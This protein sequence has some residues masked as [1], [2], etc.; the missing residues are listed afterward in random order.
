MAFYW[1][2]PHGNSGSFQSTRR[3]GDDEHERAASA[4]DRY[5]AIEHHYA[6]S[7]RHDCTRLDVFRFLFGPHQQRRARRIG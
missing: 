7:E 4:D 3:H 1:R 6:V 2:I 5:C